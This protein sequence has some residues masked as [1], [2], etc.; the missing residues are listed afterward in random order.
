MIEKLRQLV[1]SIKDEAAALER[2]L[3]ACTEE[4]KSAELRGKL[5]AVRKHSYQVGGIIEAERDEWD[6][7]YKE[8]T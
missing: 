3:A 4:V 5:E 2:E 1:E 6:K 7:L 8:M